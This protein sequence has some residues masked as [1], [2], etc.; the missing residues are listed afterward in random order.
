VSNSTAPVLHVVYVSRNDMCYEC[1]A[2]LPLHVT[3]NMRC[4]DLQARG[5][6]AKMEE[7]IKAGPRYGCDIIIVIT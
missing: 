2:M 6:A 1:D 7:A 3:S 4:R 5:A